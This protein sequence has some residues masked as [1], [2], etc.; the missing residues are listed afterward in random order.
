M[1]EQQVEGRDTR[2][3]IQAVAL[4]LFTEQGYDATS[5][6]EIAERLGVTKAALYYHFK[7]K[8]EIVES[9]MG[10]QSAR[11]D[12]LIEWT[13]D[14]PRTL[15]ARKDFLRRY[16]DS[17]ME[18]QHHKIMRFF[19]RNQATMKDRRPT[20]DFRGRMQA[21]IDYLVDADATPGRRLRASMALFTLHACWFVLDPDKIS[22]EERMKTA[23]EMADELIEG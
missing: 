5:L 10:D 7:S 8:E 22:D 20:K 2:S 23:L 4:E 3:R 17:M 16:A 15:E 21:M 6:R 13:A 14:Q 12:K 1:S 9:F 11:I 18:G 19:E